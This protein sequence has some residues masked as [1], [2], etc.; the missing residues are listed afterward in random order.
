MN[1]FTVTVEESDR[2]M[3]ILAL[4]RLSV[5]RPGWLSA[6]R[7]VAEKFGGS[8]ASHMFDDF[9][10]FSGL[11][12]GSPSD[13]SNH[14][15]VVRQ[16]DTVAV[17]KLKAEQDKPLVFSLPEAVLLAAWLARLADPNL[18]EFNRVAREIVK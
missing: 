2:Q 17:L 18:I 14:F 10:V 4:A 7:L 11:G 8:N 1:E 13:S 6:T 15:E 3:V 5:Q 12:P 16:H 9:R